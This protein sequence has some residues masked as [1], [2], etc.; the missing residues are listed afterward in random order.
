MDRAHSSGQGATS[1]PSET[2]AAAV[3]ELR[4]HWHDF[5]DCDSFPTSEGFT[6]RMEAAGLIEWRPVDDD[7]L[8]QAFADEKGIEPGGMVYDLTD[9]GRTAYKATT[10]SSVGTDGREA[11]GS[12]QKHPSITGENRR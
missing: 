10:A 5:C 3:A 12:A 2:E 11:T 6:D 8:E 4:A 1:I 9:K 7:D